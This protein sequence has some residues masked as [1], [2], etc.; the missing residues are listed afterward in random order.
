MKKIIKTLLVCMTLVLVL[1]AV[2]G[3]DL[4]TQI[5]QNICANKGHTMEAIAEKLATCT[6][7]GYSSGVVCSNCGYAERQSFKLDAKGHDMAPATCEAPSTCKR[8]DC[9]HTEGD[10]LG[11][12]MVDVPALPHTCTE[13]GYTAHKACDR[14]GCDHT[15]GKEVDPAA[16]FN[17][18]HGVC[19]VCGTAYVATLEELTYALA[20]ANV[21]VLNDNIL[22]NGNIS[23]PAEKK[24][25]SA[26]N[27]ALVGA[28]L[29]MGDKSTVEGV[30]FVGTASETG[31]QIYAHDVSVVINGCTFVDAGWDAIQATTKVDNVVIYI[32]NCEF[33]MDTV[34]SY[35]Y[36]H[37]EIV[38]DLRATANN[39]KVVI[40]GN[41]FWYANLCG[42]DAITVAG[43]H[44]ANVTFAE[45]QMAACTKAAGTD[46]L[47]F[48]EIVDGAW[49]EYDA[50]A[51]VAIFEGYH[52]VIPAT[53]TTPAT[54]AACGMV[55][56]EL[57]PHTDANEDAKCDVCGN[58]FL[59]EVGTA[60]KLK[61]VQ[62]S[63]GQTLYF[64]G[65]MSGYY[66]ATSTNAADAVDLYL[67]E[68]EGGYYIYFLDGET[69][70][71]LY[72]EISGSYTNIK[73]GETK[74]VWNLHAES[75]AL[76]T[77]VNGTDC[78]L[79]TYGTYVTIGVSKIS[80]ITGSN[81]SKVDVSQFIA[82]AV[83]V[84]ATE[85]AE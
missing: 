47:W 10:A 67:E 15:E 11:H 1:V 3:C 59:P 85:D 75:G 82:R 7:D 40:G 36:I 6:E 17:D 76:V 43:P 31:S 33:A 27:Y 57:A 49:A 45:N 84:A 52:F 30:I 81:A 19:T 55:G 71:Y 4:G 21:I 48:G 16:H 35:R 5:K 64:T 42:D 53:C 28:Q 68:A 14:D 18:E 26:G 9:G 41:L 32:A 61:M 22:V 34:A 54:C 80:Y 65:A 60:F 25:T 24:L 37:I 39:V 23:L 20:N 50:S 66:L 38:E 58:Y 29:Y 12:N 79:G 78:Y 74:G 70:N 51:G 72:V 69:K 8:T 44:A 63:Q 13:D 62:A 83:V 77:N 56:T 2:T 46:E 73:F